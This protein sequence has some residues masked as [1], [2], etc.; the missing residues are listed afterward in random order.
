VSQTTRIDYATLLGFDDIVNGGGPPRD[1]EARLATGSY[2][3]FTVT[4][5][6]LFGPIV[7]GPMEQGVEICFPLPVTPGGP[8]P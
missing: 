8:Q 7:S 3:L 5:S 4:P 6:G 2:E 1:V